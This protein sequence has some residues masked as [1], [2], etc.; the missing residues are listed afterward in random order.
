MKMLLHIQFALKF[1]SGRTNTHAEGLRPVF[2]WGAVQF[3]R[4]GTYSYVH[5]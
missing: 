5:R 4:V 1:A 2:S 3:R